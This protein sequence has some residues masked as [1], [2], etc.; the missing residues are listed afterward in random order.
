MLDVDIAQLEDTVTEIK[1]LLRDGLIAT[2]VWDIETGL[3]LA[4]HNPQPEATALF[5]LLTQEMQRTLRGSGFPGLDRY[6]ILDLEQSNIVV[7][8]LHGE[9]MMSGMLL[10]A[11]R[12]NLGVLVSVAIPRYAVGVTKAR[13]GGDS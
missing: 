12:T 13:R 5:N 4:G 8:Q 2:D 1:G 9:D 7:C 3:S 10:D 11:N 6:Y